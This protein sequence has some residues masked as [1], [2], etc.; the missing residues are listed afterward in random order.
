M[1]PDYVKDGEPCSSGCAQH[2]THACEKCGRTQ[3]RGALIRDRRN[4]WQVV[5]KKMKN[6]ESNMST[7]NMFN[8]MRIIT[9]LDMVEEGTP[10][11]VK[12]TWKERLFTLPW[13]PF[14]AT[15]TA[16]P[17]IPKQTAT[18]LPNGTLVMHPEMYD[19]IQ[20]EN[21]YET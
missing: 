16:V 1:Q 6:T 20:K 12:R 9:S 8:G 14:Y 17:L 7:P 19:K 4:M 3:A 5:E 18:F 13:K 2:V 21:N 11:E 15:K 10:Y